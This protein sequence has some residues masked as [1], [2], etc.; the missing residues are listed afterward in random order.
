[1]K[2]IISKIALICIAQ[3]I[4]CLKLSAQEKEVYIPKNILVLDLKNPESQWCRQRMKLTPNFTILWEKGFGDNPANAQPLNG[5]S[6][7]YN[8]DEFSIA[9]E[10]IFSLYR[11]KLKFVGDNS[12]CDKYRMV[13]HLKYSDE[14]TAWGGSVD[15]EIGAIW[16]TPIHQPRKEHWNII[17]HEIGHAFQ[18]QI[19]CDKSPHD[20]FGRKHGFCENCSQWGLWNYNNNWVRDELYH[21]ENYLKLTHKPFFHRVLC[22]HAPYVLEYWA[23][24]YGKTFIGELYREGHNGEDVVTVYKRIKKMNQIQFCDEIF[25][26]FCHTVNLDFELNWKNNRDLGL[27]FGIDIPC[28]SGGDCWQVPVEICPETYGYNAINID[29]PS[30]GQTITV[31]FE[32]IIPQAP[33]VSSHPEK[34]GWRYGFVM[35]DD[36]GKSYYGQKS[37]SSIGSV[38]FTAPQDVVIKKLWLIVMGAPTLHWD[39]EDDEN[40]TDSQW[41]YRI[42]VVYDE[43]HSVPLEITIKKAGELQQMAETDSRINNAVSL[44]INGK[45]NGTDVLKL[46]ELAGRSYEGK[47]TNGKL[48]YLDLLDAEIVDGGV[49]YSNNIELDDLGTKANVFPEHFFESTKIR[50]VILPIS[51]KSI[52][53]YAF[54]SCNELEEV[55]YGNHIEKIDFAAFTYSNLSEVFISNGVYNMGTCSFY[56][57]NNLKKVFVGANLETIPRK[58]FFECQNLKEIVLGEN[59][60]RIEQDAFAGC[61]ELKSIICQNVQP[62]S[63]ADDSFSDFNYNNAIVYVPKGSGNLY[64]QTAGW[65]NFKTIVELE[66][67]NINEFIDANLHQKK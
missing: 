42:K 30:P 47:K 59:L 26:A 46:R 28:N 9:I 66:T 17:A 48:K 36:N 29:I 2:K 53:R 57:M 44:K 20:Y 6:M 41:P 62:C 13:V 14:T 19:G 49:R 58:T 33:Y 54:G 67:T 16:I 45:I 22:G 23:E 63:I 43:I 18:Q 10:E 35:V 1:M 34:A 60:R 12:K 7:N 55:A 11:Y 38:S 61:L 8:L 65:K 21:L 37:S 64:R 32:G 3:F 5:I 51:T 56:K 31:N 24:K 25:D 15:N 50:K 27:K 39:I 4:F 52:G 40:A